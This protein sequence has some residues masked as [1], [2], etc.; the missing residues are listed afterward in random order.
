MKKNLLIKKI[1]KAV[2]VL[3]FVYLMQI[4]GISKCGSLEPLED[5]FITHEAI[6]EGRVI[7][8]K[9]KQED[10]FIKEVRF[11]VERVWKGNVKEDVIIL[12]YHFPCGVR[13]EEKKSYIVYAYKGNV[14][15]DITKFDERKGHF[16]NLCQSGE[17]ND[18]I[19]DRLNQLNRN[20]IIYTKSVIVFRE[21]DTLYLS[22]RNDSNLVTSVLIILFYLGI[23]VFHS[24]IRHR[25]F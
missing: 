14:D 4:T 3:S 6:F 22:Q 20:A 19:R 9:S 1:G 24:W 13:F 7:D 18:K 23:G 17:S 25:K 21:N 10:R 15:F 5:L 11:Q 16:V 2:A 8:I 12:M